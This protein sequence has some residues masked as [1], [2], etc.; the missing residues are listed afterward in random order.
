LIALAQPARGEGIICQGG[1]PP[2]SRNGGPIP[3]FLQ[4]KL[5]E[6]AA[7]AGSDSYNSY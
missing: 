5:S 3:P 7:L 6:D 1:D 2:G 4:E